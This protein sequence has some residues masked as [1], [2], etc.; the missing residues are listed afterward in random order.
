MFKSIYFIALLS[1]L[2][3]CAGVLLTNT[4]IAWG[5]YLSY[6]GL[7]VFTGLFIKL[8]FDWRKTVKRNKEK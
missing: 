8:C 2:L 7:T 6:A 1:F 4:G 3:V 5:I